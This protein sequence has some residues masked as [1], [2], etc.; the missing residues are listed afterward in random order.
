ML[1]HNA[2]A[3]RAVLGSLLIDPDALYEVQDTGLDASDFFVER[4]ALIYRAICDTA[5]SGPM[6]YL[7][8]ID[9]LGNRQNGHGSQL[10]AVGGPA[11]IT[12]LIN[13][14][15]TF[16]HAAHYAAMVRRDAYRR[17]VI[18]MC[19]DAAALAQ[20]HDGTMDELANL[21]GERFLSVAD[22]AQDDGAYMFGSDEVLADYLA[23]QA[24]RAELLAGDPGALFVTGLADLDAI[25]GHIWGVHVVA[26]ESSVGKTM[27]MEQ[28]AEANAKRGKKVA[29]YHLELEHQDMADRIFARYSTAD[30]MELRRGYTDLSD[31][32]TRVRP[33]FANIVYVYCPGWTAERIAGDMRRLHARGLC[34]MAI[35]DYLQMIP[36]GGDAL[37]RN[38]AQAV[39]E[40]VRVLKTCRDQLRIPLVLAS[41]MSRPERGKRATRENIRNSG[42]PLEKGNQVVVLHR[43][44]STEEQERHPE[45]Y[46]LAEPLE[47]WVEKNTGYRTGKADIVHVKGRFLLGNAAHNNDE[48]LPI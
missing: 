35:V 10:D 7:R 27:Y 23:N 8:L 9:L 43:K 40:Q 17:K 1:P 3:E 12:N 41:Q 44:Y 31:A 38:V 14:C 18:G 28:V 39:G 33:W 32:I 16:L 11:A 30:F 46:A 26:A 22:A 19:A 34:Q 25:L 47:A 29:Y 4:H 36:I 13:A 6:D 5:R 48:P 21:V 42:E 24:A 15:P 45:T 2:E 20:A 37:G